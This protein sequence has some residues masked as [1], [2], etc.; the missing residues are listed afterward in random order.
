MLGIEA[1]EKDPEAES[2][3]LPLDS[4]MGESP[5]GIDLHKPRCQIRPRLRGHM[6]TAK[7]IFLS[8]GRNLEYLYRE[9]TDMSKCGALRAQKNS[10]CPKSMSI[11]KFS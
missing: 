9:S 6:Q 10:L 4:S 1:R 11:Y 2:P 5:S 7:T 3:T 8:R